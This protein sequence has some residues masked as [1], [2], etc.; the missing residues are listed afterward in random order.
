MSMRVNDETDDFCGH[1]WD[2][3]GSTI[4]SCCACEWC[5]CAREISYWCCCKVLGWCPWVNM[6]VCTKCVVWPSWNGGAGGLHQMCDATSAAQYVELRGAA[7]QLSILLCSH[8][9]AGYMFKATNILGLHKRVRYPGHWCSC[10]HPP[11]MHTST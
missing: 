2:V 4:A 8:N 7:C 10:K 1:V 5:G 3:M 6:P 9:S 11:R